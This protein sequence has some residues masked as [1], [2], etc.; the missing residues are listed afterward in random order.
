MNDSLKWMHGAFTDKLTYYRVHKSRGY[1]ENCDV[2]GLSG[3][4]GT[5]RA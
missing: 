1:E 4:A 2:D 3:F 5:A